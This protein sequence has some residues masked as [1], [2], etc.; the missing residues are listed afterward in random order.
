[1]LLRLGHT[2]ALPSIVAVLAL[3][4][5]AGSAPAP[6]AAPA[7]A[8]NGTGPDEVVA[9]FRAG[10]AAFN[11]HDLDGFMEQF[12][13]DVEMYAPTGWLRGKPDVRVRFETTFEHF[14]EV[15]MEVEDLRAREVAA[16]TVVVDFRWRVFPMGAGPAFHGTGTGVYVRRDGRWVEVLEHETVTQVDPGLPQPPR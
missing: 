15:R 13:E 11:A 14:P 10:I 8:G 4:A 12:A 3:A 2:L 1:M 5:C 16:G 7:V 9:T 6:S